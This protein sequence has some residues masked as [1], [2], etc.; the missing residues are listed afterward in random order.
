MQIILTGKG[1]ELTEAI[2][3]YVSKKLGGVDKFFSEIQRAEVVVGMETQH[4]NKGAVFFAECKLEVPGNSL[5][6]K[7][8]GVS[9]YEAVDF[10]K[11]QL[12]SEVKKHKLKLQ[13]NLKKKREVS[14]DNKEYHDEV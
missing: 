2:S 8:V 7:T 13:G 3:A 4:H 12:E 1:V 14:R 5:F 11:A 6:A 9:L 10:L